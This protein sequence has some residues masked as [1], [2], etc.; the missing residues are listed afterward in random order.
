MK[1]LYRLTDRG[2]LCSNQ[3]SHTSENGARE[4]ATCAY[5]AHIH[6]QSSI[7]NQQNDAPE[8]PFCYRL[9][10]S[11]L[12]AFC[13]RSCPQSQLTCIH[14][15]KCA[16]VLPWHHTIVHRLDHPPALL[17]YPAFSA[18]TTKQDYI[19]RFTRNAILTLLRHGNN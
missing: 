14:L 19:S 5:N 4:A 1:R 18:N 2:A 16:L 15:C 7:C 13:S 8:T 9:G 3:L 6:P 17:P 11:R 10:R 12:L